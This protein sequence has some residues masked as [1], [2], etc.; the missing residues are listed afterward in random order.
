[1]EL[2]SESNGEGGGGS[3]EWNRVVMGIVY[4]MVCGIGVYM[5]KRVV[6]VVRMNRR[7]ER[8]PLQGYKWYK[9]GVLFEVLIRQILNGKKGKEDLMEKSLEYQAKLGEIYVGFVGWI[10]FVTI[11]G[12]AL[13]REVSV[14][15]DGVH[16]KKNF[17]YDLSSPLLGSSLLLSS[18]SFWHSQRKVPSSPS[19]LYSLYLII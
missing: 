8:L 2:S 6:E 18:G 11:N 7:L 5:I 19:P 4:M 16:F 13:I 1:M 3:I 12:G 10:G 15:S 14:K 17:G 9:G